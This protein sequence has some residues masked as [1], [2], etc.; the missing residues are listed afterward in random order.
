MTGSY[1][2]STA[3]MTD[4]DAFP[5][6]YA[7][8]SVIKSSEPGY[9]VLED[10]RDGGLKVGVSVDGTSGH[11]QILYIFLAQSVEL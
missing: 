10:G 9:G 8:H 3:A 4:C 7:T 2:A 6:S 11:S 1:P 5:I